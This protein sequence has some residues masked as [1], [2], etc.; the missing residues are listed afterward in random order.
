M[1]KGVLTH[2]RNCRICGRSNLI[3]LLDLGMAPLANAFLTKRALRNPEPRFPLVVYFCKNC[4][5]LQLLDIVIPELLFRN[6][7]YFTSTSP[8]LAEHFIELGKNLTRRFIASKKDL[9]IDIGG[10]DA[11]LL[12]GIKSKCRVLNIEPAKNIAKTSKARDIDTIPEFFSRKLANKI[13]KQYGAA[14]VIT[15]SN[16]FAHTDDP[17][18]I[19]GGVK[20]LI[21]SKGVFVIETHWVANLLGLAGAGSFDQIYHEHLSYF[22]LSALRNLLGRAGLK[23]FD[24]R[25]I[26]VHGQSLQVYAAMGDFAVSGSVGKILKREKKLGLQK[27]ATYLSFARKVQKNKHQLKH[28]LL[29]LKKEGN[30][31]VGYGAPAKGNILL[32][33]FQIDDKILDFI[34]D[35]APA[36]Q[37]LY[38]PG[39]HIP[40]FSI[41]KL[42]NHSPDYLLLLAWNYADFI[43]EK[44]KELRKRGVK[45][46]IPTPKVKI[47]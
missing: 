15:A 29:K 1:K 33:Y 25:L 23:I 27:T 46:I 44:E 11:A 40:I 38:T 41:N 34:I 13:L 24:A 16:V 3:K 5:L 36:K 19:M 42:K 47:I 43:L 20:T 6:Y 18:E 14:K 31:I 7:F 17:Q 12:A 26:P 8:P 21:G 35:Y 2:R 39:M 10:N 32:S 4:G 9:V 30:S 37:G 22:S 45:F 28:L